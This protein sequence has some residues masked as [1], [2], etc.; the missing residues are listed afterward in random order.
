MSFAFCIPWPFLRSPEN[1]TSQHGLSCCTEAAE[2]AE[3]AGSSHTD[4][5]ASQYMSAALL[6]L[7]ASPYPATHVRNL[8][9]SHV[10]HVPIHWQLL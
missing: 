5:E 7:Y 2:Q 3:N 4:T 9:Q 1:S 8:P 6:S 10:Y